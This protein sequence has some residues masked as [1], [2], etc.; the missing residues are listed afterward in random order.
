[1]WEL[2]RES[3]SDGSDGSI[4]ALEFERY[5]GVAGC[6]RYEITDTGWSYCSANAGILDRILA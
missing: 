6:F 1:M 2:L 3:Q 5:A 4:T